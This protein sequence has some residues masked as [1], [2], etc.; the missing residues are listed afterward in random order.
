M[1]RAARNGADLRGFAWPLSHLERKLEQDL[2]LAGLQLAGLRRAAAQVEADLAALERARGEQ[3][4]AIA[5]TPGRGV[6][7]AAHAQ[8]LRYLAQADQHAAQGRAQAASLQGRIDQAA[9]ACAGVERRV[10]CVRRWREGAEDEHVREQ[11]RRE[12]READRAWLA[13]HGR[14]GRVQGDRT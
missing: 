13:L 8:V 4:R 2:E 11:R 6:D 7:P 12:A 9:A 3:L 5:T 1:K 10:A 14:A